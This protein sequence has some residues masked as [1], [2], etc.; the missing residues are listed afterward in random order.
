MDSVMVTAVAAPNPLP[1]ADTAGCPTVLFTGNDANSNVWAWDFGDGGSATTANPSHTYAANGTYTVTATAGND[2]GTA[3]SSITV[4][5]S[6]LVAIENGF[7]NALK[8]SPNP[9]NGHFEMKLQLDEAAALEYAVTDIQGR[10][11]FQK[12]HEAAQLTWNEELRLDLE[13]GVYFLN[14]RAAG[15]TATFKLM[16]Q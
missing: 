9:S 11:V 8:V 10:V 2:C 13:A 7:E 16:I 3:N 15:K 5:V 12:A 6:C 4:T 14:V 1:A